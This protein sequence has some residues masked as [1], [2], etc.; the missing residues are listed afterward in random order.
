MA[1]QGQVLPDRLTASK[2]IAVHLNYRSRAEQRGRTPPYPSYF[3]KPS[4]TLSPGGALERPDGTELLGFEGE[5]AV[6]V[7]EPV[8]RAS[9]QQAEAAIGWVAPAGD[10]GIY[11]LRWNDRGSNVLAKGQDGFTP[12]G[13]AVPAAGLD[14]SAL[15]LTTR[16]NGD[17]AQDDSSSNLIFSF[18]E[19]IADLSRV[20]TLVRGDV[21]LTGTPAGAA[22]VEPGDVVEITLEGAGSVRSEI[23]AGPPLAAHGAPPRVTGAERAIAAGLNAPRP[24]T[25]TD[26]ARDALNHVSTATLTAQ[27]LKR[28][29]RRTF[30]TGLKPTRPHERLLGYAHTLRFGAAREDL[31]AAGKGD[32]A[33]KRAVESISPGDVLVIEARGEVGAGTIGDIL[34]ARILARGGAGIVTDGGV[35]DSPGVAGLPIPTYFRAPNAASLWTCHQPLDV[36]VPVTCAGVLVIPGDVIV[37]D[38]EGAVVIPAQLAE[39]LAHEALEQERR[40]QFAL[41]RVRAGES[42]RGLYPLS[43]ARRPEYEQWAATHAPEN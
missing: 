36:D 24:V 14:L 16:V 6:I 27:L 18:A 12:I 21:I 15:R 23:V 19:L 31:R 28:G 2:V 3:L 4:T 17:L 32:D 35:R 37:G 42:F 39:E 9:L 26:A 13:P 7:G 20:M 11:D 33:Q 1:A 22:T 25:L 30:L 10:Y 43:D 29:I 8:R 41:E 5:I 38:A 34:A 40:E